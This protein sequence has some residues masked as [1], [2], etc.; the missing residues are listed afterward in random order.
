MSDKNEVFLR[1]EASL[2]LDC[3][4]KRLALLWEDL[5]IIISHNIAAFQELKK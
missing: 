4:R 2:L 3:D 5:S 1:T